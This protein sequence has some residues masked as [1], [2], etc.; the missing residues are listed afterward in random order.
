MPSIPA[1][2]GLLLLRV[3]VGVTAIAHGWQKVWLNGL[4]GTTEGFAGMGIPFA[5]IAAPLV[6]F[7]ELIGGA[8]LVIGFAARFAA[9]LIGIA[10]SVALVLVH[11]PAGF[12][13]ADGGIELVLLLAAAAF[14]L[15]L[16]G[17]GRF[18]IDGL[19]AR[20]R[21]TRRERRYEASPA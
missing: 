16:T 13:A 7:T 19:F 17:S 11:L 6:A 20:A 21:A 8:L 10:M 12:F 1:S 2:A 9:V 3:V 18:A 15:A 14:A 4:E 5:S